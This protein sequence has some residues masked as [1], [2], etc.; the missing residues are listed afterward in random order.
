MTWWE[1]EAEEHYMTVEEYLKVM[2]LEKEN[3]ELRLQRLELEI[4]KRILYRPHRGQFIEAMCERKGFSNLKQAID[5]IIES[6]E[7]LKLL[8]NEI[9]FHYYTWDNRLAADSYIVMNKRDGYPL[10]FMEFYD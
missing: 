5:Y 9:S 4:N 6:N 10:G 1:K 8:P 3:A 7:E 2:K